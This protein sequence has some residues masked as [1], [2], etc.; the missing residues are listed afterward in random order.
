MVE[1]ELVIDDKPPTDPCT[2]GNGNSPPA[3][4]SAFSPLKAV[5]FG[6]ARI[7]SMLRDSRSAS[8]APTFSREL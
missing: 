1:I 3:R 7:C 6:S 8:V 4:N 5:M 2:T